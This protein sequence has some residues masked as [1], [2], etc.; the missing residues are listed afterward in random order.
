MAVGLFYV[1]ILGMGCHL[2]DVTK[3]DTWHVSIQSEKMTNYLNN[4][5]L[6]KLMDGFAP[7]SK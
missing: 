6:K 3:K 5:F 1:L 2:D 7:C 4:F